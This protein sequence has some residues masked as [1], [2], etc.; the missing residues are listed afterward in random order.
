MINDDRFK[1]GSILYFTPFLFLDGGKPKPKYFLVIKHIKDM[2]ILSSLPTSK[3]SVPM[4]L[5]KRHGCIDNSSINF[6]C[7]YFSPNVEIC[8]NG[9]SFPI[10]TYVYGFRLHNF[11]VNSFLQQEKNKETI[12]EH[13]GTL[14]DTELLAIRE[15]LKTSS[16]VKRKYKKLL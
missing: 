15:C 16:S 7:Y 12:I 1:E 4:Y 14:K 10:E 3:D 5:E 11:N 13:K 8:N 9:F 2:L 6:N